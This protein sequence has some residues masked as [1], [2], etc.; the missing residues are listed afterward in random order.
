MPEFTIKQHKINLHCQSFWAQLGIGEYKRE[1]LKRVLF[2]ICLLLSIPTYAQNK[3]TIKAIGDLNYPPYSY[4][5]EDGEIVGYSI[6]VAKAIFE[7]AGLDYTIE[8]AQWDTVLSDFEKKKVDAIIGLN[9]SEERAAKYA[10]NFAMTYVYYDFITL[11]SSRF[12]TH[13]DLEGK[14]IICIKNYL[15]C[16]Y[17]DQIDFTD[18]IITAPNLSQGLQ[19]LLAGKGDALMCDRKVAQYYIKKGYKANTFRS[20]PADLPPFEHAIVVHLDDP[21][22]LLKLDKAFFVVKEN[23]SLEVISN[24]WFGEKKYFQKHK[25][26]IYLLGFIT[27]GLFI[28]FVFIILQRRNIAMATAKLRASEA[29]LIK[30]KEKVEHSDRLKSLFLANMSH[31]IRTPLNA[32]VGFSQL[33]TQEENSETKEEYS[34]LITTNSN[35]LL[36]IINDILDLSKIES[37]IIE[38]ESQEFD[39]S[40]TFKYLEQTLRQEVKNADVPLIAINPYKHCII[41]GDKHRLSQVITNF[42]INA[43]KFTVQGYI[44][45]GYRYEDNGLY[46]YVK[47]TGIGIEKEHQ[48]KIFERFYKINEFTQGT[49]LG[50]SICKAIMEQCNGKIG[51]ESV[52]GEGSTFWCFY[53]CEAEIETKA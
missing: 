45:M 51:V 2:M 21:K 44:E 26:L 6:D 15:S 28:T 48:E 25:D 32:I 9:Y 3:P 16:Q 12:T 40:E 43:N 33:I 41:K 30:E 38:T 1:T 53:P 4:L 35:L 27:L 34:K 10:F 19:M 36:S 49:G 7:A 8:L 52:Y 22:L 31:E 14:R 39:F 42:V 18:Q 20:I 37:G 11:S 29:S 46:I 13:R 5:N 23:G 17:L 50:M 47:D 24:K